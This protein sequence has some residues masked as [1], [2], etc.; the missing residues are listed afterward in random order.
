MWIN[1]ESVRQSKVS[2][3]DKHKYCVFMHMY[4]I[5]KNSTDEAMQD[6][7]RD[8]DAEKGLVDTVEEGEGGTN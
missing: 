5:Q 4:G 3:K 8:A 7:N 2:Q 1:L 6:R